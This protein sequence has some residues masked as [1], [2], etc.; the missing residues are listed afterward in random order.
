MAKLI[1]LMTTSLDGYVEDPSGDIGFGRPTDPELHSFIMQYVSSFQTHLYG[2]RMYETMVYWETAPDDESESQ[3]DRD[4]A[5]LWRTAQKVVY[6]RSLA[7]VSSARTTIERVFDP[8]SV[9]RRKAEAT[10]DIVISGPELAGH[11][12]RAGLV[13]EIQVILSPVILGGGKRFFPDGVRF[14][15]T[16]LEERRFKNGS[17]YLRYAV[18][19]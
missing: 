2:R 18:S 13:D 8:E 19:L 17:I 9:R 16:S 1:Y 11:A 7:E 3:F 12:I 10:T 15:L 6:S 14:G 5:R 4:F